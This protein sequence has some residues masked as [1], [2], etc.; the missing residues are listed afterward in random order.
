MNVV[1]FIV[2]IVRP[3]MYVRIISVYVLHSVI[4]EHVVL[5]DALLLVEPVL[6]D[7]TVGVINVFQ[8]LDKLQN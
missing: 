2:R 3:V 5:T 7:Y 1:F 8:Q 6:R 4:L